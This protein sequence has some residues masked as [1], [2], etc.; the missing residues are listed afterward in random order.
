MVDIALCRGINQT[1]NQQSNSNNFDQSA[2]LE[3]QQNGSQVAVNTNPFH[4]FTCQ[5][6]KARKQ[7]VDFLCQGG[8]IKTFYIRIAT[9]C[10]F[11]RVYSDNNHY[12]RV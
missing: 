7:N 2:S 10:R 5:A 11:K 6:S 1:T 9:S 8:E 12:P 4:K 3:T